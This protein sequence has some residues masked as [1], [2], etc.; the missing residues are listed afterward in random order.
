MF[1]FFSLGLG[2]SSNSNLGQIWTVIQRP[3]CASVATDSGF[4][5]QSWSITTFWSSQWEHEGQL[6]GEGLGPEGDPVLD[7]ISA[8]D[9]CAFVFKSIT[10]EWPIYS[11]SQRTKRREGTAKGESATG[12]PAHCRDPRSPLTLSNIP[13]MADKMRQVGKRMQVPPPGVNAPHLVLCSTRA[14]LSWGRGGNWQ[15]QPNCPRLI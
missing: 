9:S 14:A 13:V 7:A 11:T 12:E 15:D 10:W 3:S 2:Q 1:F 6:D 8:S 5:I 4:C